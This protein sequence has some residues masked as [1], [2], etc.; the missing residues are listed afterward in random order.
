MG[1]GVLIF[2]IIGLLIFLAWIEW[3]IGA[4]IGKNVTRLTGLVVGIVCIVFCVSVV[5]GIACI[6]YSQKNLD[7]PIDI[8]IDKQS[9]S[10]TKECPHC[11][12]TI[13]KNATTCRFCGNNV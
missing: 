3:L 9:S 5:T 1:I 4:L 13:K 8:K 6:I 7:A 10:D 2:I 11:A 12:E